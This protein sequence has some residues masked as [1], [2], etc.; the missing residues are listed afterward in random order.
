[1]MAGVRGP[2]SNDISAL[3]FRRF[4]R[5]GPTVSVELEVSVNTWG[6]RAVSHCI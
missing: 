3:S 6:W 5:E 2:S 4:T 1:M